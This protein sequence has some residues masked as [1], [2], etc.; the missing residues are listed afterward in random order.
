VSQPDESALDDVVVEGE[1]V[2]GE[3]VGEEE[4]VEDE[5][6]ADFADADVSIEAM[7][8]DLE[9]MVAERDQFL[10]AY[11][12]AQADFEN[13]RK[14]T[15]RRQ[16]DAV[17]R[18]ITSLVVQMLPVLDAGDA[19]RSHG[20]DDQLANLLYD[21][22]SKDGLE[23]VEADPGTPFDPNVHDAVA[24]EPGDGAEPQVAGVLRTG[25]L[26]KGRVIRP[27]MVTVKG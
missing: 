1:V 14:Q 20:E 27:A 12:R 10:D 4:V 23:A 22:L 6:I 26:W 5:V 2:E 17:D 3:I 25:Y 15:V 18:A 9:A 11:R 7:I 8:G 24:H 16:E 21:T 19:A 13:F